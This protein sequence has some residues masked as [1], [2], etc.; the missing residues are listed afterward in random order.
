MAQIESDT[1]KLLRECASGVQMGVESIREVLSHVKNAELKARLEKCREEHSRLGDEVHGLLHR[2]HDKGKEPNPMAKGMS[3]LKTNVTLSWN[4]GDDTIADLM[5]QGCDM[6]VKSLSRYLNQYA[7]AQEWAKD[8]AKKLIALE[9]TL[10]RDL[11]P[12]L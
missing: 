2:Y 10:A 11:R 9:E 12:Y 8:A 4:P 6:G 5:T 3:W 1:V 7:A